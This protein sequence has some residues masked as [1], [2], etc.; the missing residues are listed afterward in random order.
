MLQQFVERP[1]AQEFTAPVPAEVEGYHAAIEMPM[2]L[3]T[4]LDRLRG[5][6]YCTYRARRPPPPP[7]EPAA[8]PL[9][10]L[11]CML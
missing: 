6:H 11:A 10:A 3:G 8:A 7:H 2:D 4:V 5:G 1:E 9:K